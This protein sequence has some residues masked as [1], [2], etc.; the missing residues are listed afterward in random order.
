MIERLVDSDKN[1][2]REY[3]E[4][5]DGQR[6]PIVLDGVMKEHGWTRS[7]EYSRWL[8]AGGDGERWKFGPVILVNSSFDIEE[9]FRSCRGF[10]AMHEVRESS[11]LVTV[12]FDNLHRVN[13]GQYDSPD[14][15]YLVVGGLSSFRHAEFS[16]FSR[17]LTHEFTY[18]PSSIR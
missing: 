15:Q 5:G 2:T 1:F 17:R 4:T 11:G 6:Y 16:L 9:A 3:I 18:H 10:A 7:G 8:S 13:G 14:T 12:H